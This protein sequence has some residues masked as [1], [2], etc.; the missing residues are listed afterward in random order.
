MM[1]L[2]MVAFKTDGDYSWCLCG[3]PC[4]FG[5]S[6]KLYPVCVCVCLGSRIAL[7]WHEAKS[8][9]CLGG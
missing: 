3:R 9:V 4:N 1:V 2:N 8:T 7:D 6:C 5:M